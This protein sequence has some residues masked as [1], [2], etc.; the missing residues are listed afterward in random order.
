MFDDK[1][2]SAVVN[3]VVV[4]L[5]YCVALAYPL[6][7]DLQILRRERLRVRDFLNSKWC[8]R[9]NQRH[10]GVKKWQP[11]S[12]YYE[13]QRECR[14]GGNKL[15]NVRSFSIL[16]SGEGSTSFNNDNSA[17]FSGEKKCNEEFRGV[18]FLT[19]REKTLNQISYSQSF[20]SSNLKVSQPR[21]QGSLLSALRSEQERT[22]GTR[23]KVS[24][25]PLG[26]TFLERFP[27]VSGFRYVTKRH[28]LIRPEKKQCT[29]DWTS[30]GLTVRGLHLAESLCGVFSGLL[31]QYMSKI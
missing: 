3:Q 12:F 11:S 10:F 17:N 16:Q 7:R 23:L 8:S 21:S 9:V 18:Y 5:G 24:S 13:F 27:A 31:C 1:K 15:S 26:V 4:Y 14:S 2:I 20:S 6:S 30:E 19:I 29:S 25:V 22:L 28:D